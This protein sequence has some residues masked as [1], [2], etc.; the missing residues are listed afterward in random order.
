MI[1]SCDTR[2]DYVTLETR[3]HVSLHWCALQEEEGKSKLA[4][5]G[6]L[7][8]VENLLRPLKFWQR[9]R[10]SYSTTESDEEPEVQLA[11]LTRTGKQPVQ[12]GNVTECALLMFSMSLG[13]EPEATRAAN[14]VEGF[15][16]VGRGGTSLD[17]HTQHMFTVFCTFKVCGGFKGHSR[18]NMALHH[19][20]CR[21]VHFSSPLSALV[22]AFLH[23]TVVE[24][25]F[26]AQ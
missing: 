15:V 6:W 25:L 10:A 3:G 9:G 4:N 24:M 18:P 11:V 14:P 13:L 23:E 26:I 19:I 8:R 12:V 2:H 16:K 22:R 17:A 5:A 21:T 1:W 7:A 20:L